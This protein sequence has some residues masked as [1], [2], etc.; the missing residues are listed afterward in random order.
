MDFQLIDT[1]GDFKAY[2][3]DLRATGLSDEEIAKDYAG[4]GYAVHFGTHPEDQE[5]FEPKHSSYFVSEEAALYYIETWFE[6]WAKANGYTPPERTPQALQALSRP[7]EEALF[8][9][10]LWVQH[11][12]SHKTAAHHASWAASIFF[13]DAKVISEWSTTSMTEELGNESPFGEPVFW[14][15]QDE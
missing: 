12:G 3:E 2:I 1:N 13:G 6:T 7:Q 5:C 11:F 4:N 10:F 15:G 9:L 8:N 14:Y